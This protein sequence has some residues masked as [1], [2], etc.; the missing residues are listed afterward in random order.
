MAVE[1]PEREE[2]KQSAK[3]NVR[4]EL[5][6][7]NPF[8]RNSWIGSVVIAL[9]LL[10][11]D[12]YE[13]LREL[14]KQAFWDTAEFPW[15]GR[16]ASIF[17]IQRNAASQA[18]GN[19][20]AEGIAGA[21]IPA[22]SSLSVSGIQYITTANAAIANQVLSITSLTRSGGTV[23]ATTASDH[24]LATGI[25]V[26]VAGAVETEYNGTFE[27]TIS[28]QFK[29][30]FTYQIETTPATPATGTITASSDTA[31]IAIQ[32]GTD[33]FGAQTNQ[34]TGA[35]LIFSPPILNVNDNCFVDF[36]G[37]TGGSDQEST[38]D[39]RIRFLDRVQKPVANFNDSAIEQKA[40]EITGNTRVFI[41]DAFPNKG[42]VT[43]YFT[44]DNDGIIPTADDVTRTKNKILEIKPGHTADVD[45]IVN[46]PTP[47]TVNFIFASLNPN[48]QT[49]Q[50]AINLN[51]DAFFEEKTSVGQDL[52][53]NEYVAAIQN[54]IDI[55]T[56]DRLITFSLTTPTGTIAVALGEIPV[57]GTVNFP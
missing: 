53:E 40:K 14:L 11:S 2:L 3:A 13:Q 12:W 51:L 31:L 30:Q 6:N 56:G 15:L 16:W 55:T 49:M 17:D 18:T 4:S 29:N 10:L 33:F 36:D 19:V 37:L 34:D 9:A 41:T 50:D 44:R 52:T 47:K 22:G 45:V 5:D 57:K 43:I 23:T 7:S 20:V 35:A 42:Q 28:L 1:F 25:N 26:T 24:N 46:A 8:L 54:T 27:I 32:A 48:T 21:A 38:E 39:N